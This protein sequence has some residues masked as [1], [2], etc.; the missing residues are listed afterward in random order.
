MLP[1]RSPH[2]AHRGLR[3]RFG[4]VGMRRAAAGPARP[5]AGP[6]RPWPPPPD[7][8]RPAQSSNRR[9]GRT[10]TGLQRLRPGP[11]SVRCTSSAFPPRSRDAS[12]R[13]IAASTAASRMGAALSA[14]TMFDRAF[15]TNS[16]S[17]LRFSSV[18][19]FAPAAAGSDV[20]PAVHAAF[21]HAIDVRSRVT[22][23]LGVDRTFRLAMMDLMVETLIYFG[24]ACLTSGAALVIHG[25]NRHRI[26]G[27]N[28]KAGRSR[29]EP[30]P[31]SEAG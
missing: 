29:S 25:G 4:Q 18:T 28:A 2:R 16:F 30:I 14:W 19:L 11:S 6:P 7:R 21:S 22:A 23:R 1:A 12:G 31:A 13:A 26:V 17:C 5:G 15:G 3:L 10:L 9:P 20:R 24:F 8:P 27:K